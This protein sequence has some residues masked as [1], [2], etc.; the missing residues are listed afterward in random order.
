MRLKQVR[1]MAVN[2]LFIRLVSWRH[3]YLFF[4]SPF[5]THVL[6]FFTNVHIHTI[7][8]VLAELIQNI[9]TKFFHLLHKIRTSSKRVEPEDGSKSVVNSLRVLC[10]PGLRQALQPQRPLS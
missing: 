6:S 9:P 4:T 3:S 7:A 2:V 10:L 1:T 8:L 5:K